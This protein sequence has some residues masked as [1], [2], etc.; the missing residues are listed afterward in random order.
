MKLKQLIMGTALTAALGV[1][2]YSTV[3]AGTLTET[4]KDGK[5]PGMCLQTL[6]EHGIVSQSAYDSMNSYMKAHASSKN[7]K[8]KEKRERTID[9]TNKREQKSPYQHCVASGLISQETADAIDAYMTAQRESGTKKH[10]SF[11]T[12]LSESLITQTEYQALKENMEQHRSKEKSTSDKEHIKKNGKQNGIFQ[13]MLTNGVISQSDY[14][15]II[16][17]FET[18]RSQDV[19]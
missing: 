14:D 9:N 1:F 5:K 2:S 17:Y 7:D 10:I 13:D 6:L 4:A 18:S 16:S 19:A 12:L 15:A 3:F 8:Q 11:D